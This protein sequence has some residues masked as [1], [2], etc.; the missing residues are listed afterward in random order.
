M[1]MAW[2]LLE[3]KCPAAPS[4]LSLLNE[5]APGVL[6]DERASPGHYALPRETHA[7]ICVKTFLNELQ[8]C[9]TLVYPDIL[10]RRVK[11]PNFKAGVVT[12]PC[13]VSAQK[14]KAEGLL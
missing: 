12:C 2:Q 5:R 1:Q 13:H 6:T 14:A 4:C 8:P 10:C 9:F 3:E 11:Y 7:E